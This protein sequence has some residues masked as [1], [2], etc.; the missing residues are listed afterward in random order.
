MSVC[1]CVCVYY[2]LYAASSPPDHFEVTNITIKTVRLQ[3]A[4]PSALNGKLQGYRLVYWRTNGSLNEYTPI[5]T[6]KLSW[7]V[8]GLYPQQ[9]Y[10]FNLTAVNGVGYG[11]KTVVTA[12]TNPIG[13]IFHLFVV[14]FN[15]CMCVHHWMLYICALF[16]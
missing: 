8:N 11:N 14:Y 15:V 5:K 6:E 10:V 7:T 12:T 13:Q 1:V 3:W 9:E 2:V 4:V 16:I